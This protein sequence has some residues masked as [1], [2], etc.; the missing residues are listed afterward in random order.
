[1]NSVWQDLRYGTRML[2]KSRGFALVA[3]VTL[4]LG[5]GINT[6]IFSVVNAVLLK[7]LP[8]EKPE[9]IVRVYSTNE[10]RGITSNPFSYP[11]FADYRA[12][13]QTFE[14]LAAYT[15]ASAALSGGDTPEQV[16]GVATSVD[17]FKVLGTPALKGRTFAP[18]DEREGGGTAVVISHGMW[19]RRFGGDPN[20]VGRQISLDGLSKTIIGVMPEGFQFLFVNDQPE[21]WVPL[22]P[23]GGMNI[24]RG[25]IYLSVLG[26]LRPNVTIEQA[27]AEMRTIAGR[28]AEQYK[29]ENA[30]RSVNLVPALEDMTEDLRPTLLVLLGA[31][32]FVLLIACANV[33]NLLLA[34]AAGRGREMAIRAAHGASRW[35]I[36]RQLLTESLLLALLGGGLGLL[37]AVWG[38]E[39]LASVVPADIPRF[40]QTGVDLSVLA[41]TFLASMLTGV[42]FG[43][44]PAMQA[45]RL[46]LNEALKEGGRSSTGGRVRNRVRSILIVSEVA[47]SLVLLVGAGLLIKSFIELRSV[48]PGFNPQNALTAS[49]SLPTVRYKENEK[50]RHFYQQAIERV[51]QLPNVEAVGAIMPLPYS[52]N[53]MSI[54][55]TVDGRPE[56]PPSERPA[57][58]ARISTPGYFS[59]MGIPLV[60][61]RVFTDQDRADSPKVI[62]I[63]ETFARKHFPGEDPVGRRLQLGMNSI[64]GEI[65]GVVGDVRSSRLDA[66]AGAEFYVPF[67]QVPVHDLSLVVRTRSGDPAALAPLM[68]QAVQEIDKDQPLYEVQTMSRL[69][70]SSIA[71][72]RFSMTLVALFALL[73]LALASVGIFSVMSFLV[74]QRTHEIGIRMALGAQASDVLRMILGQGMLFTLLGLVLG[75][76][77]AFALTRLMSGLLFKVRATDPLIF[78]GVS[79]L[80]A[81]VAFIACYLPARRATRV[82]PMQALHY[83]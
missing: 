59:A 14:A 83:E 26:R 35:R 5:I 15:G 11:N 64:N 45:S 16:A 34:R 39:L 72:Q 36:I 22:D 82:D 69:V 12:E 65:V 66:E 40:D 42:I 68:R 50:V 8:Y 19:Q 24:Q 43:F 58:G 20:I 37:L 25:A 10:K 67:S 62:L 79:L 4:A 78:I 81:M 7:P 76:I 77:S 33:A 48:N 54:S 32:G 44:A 27:G 80:L 1:M 56:P 28:L 9:R 61:G 60:R 55:F 13:Q 31:V 38:V 18:E 3:V 2:L 29:S 63:N 47:L 46:D 52:N 71:R 49:V 70:A 21:F 51:S 23:K 75:L 17:L 57:S 74:T 53:A 73:A 41:F 6:A 30:N